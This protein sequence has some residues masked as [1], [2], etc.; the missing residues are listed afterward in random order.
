MSQLYQMPESG[1]PHTTLEFTS[2][3]PPVPPLPP[4]FENEFP[5]Q[6]GISQSSWFLR[7]SSV[8]KLTKERGK[9]GTRGTS[10]IPSG[11][12]LGHFLL[13]GHLLLDHNRE[14]SCFKP[15]WAGWVGRVSKD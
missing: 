6:S 4:N 9:G 1:G 7:F 2:F 13:M 5:D 8:C 10:L 15:V 3:V 11:L 14:A 12:Q